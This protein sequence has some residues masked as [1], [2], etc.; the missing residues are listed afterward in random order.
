MVGAGGAGGGAGA[1]ATGGTEAERVLAGEDGAIGFVELGR[2]VQAS[3]SKPLFGVV[4]GAGFGALVL[5]DGCGGMGVEPER[6]G[7]FASGVPAR[8]I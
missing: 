2:T 7:L 5:P 4:A 8:P 1:A 6:A 3:S